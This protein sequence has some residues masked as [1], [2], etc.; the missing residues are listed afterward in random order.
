[1]TD[2][3][4]APQG[5]LPDAWTAYIGPFAEVLGK[6]V[7]DVTELLKSIVGEPNDQ[8][9]ILLKDVA[10]SPDADLKALLVGT[11]SAI[12]NQAISKLREMPVSHA[13]LAFSGAD[14]LPEVPSEES[15][16]S[17][18]RA[19][20]QL[21]VDQPSVISVVRASLAHRVGLFN[22]PSILADKMESFA[23]DNAQP[24][25]EEFYK[26]RKQVT[27]RNYGEIFAAIDGL[28]GSFISDKRRNELLSRVDTI[29]WPALFDF[30]SQLKAWV[31]AW[32][33]GAANPALMMNAIAA[34]AGGGSTMPPGMMAPPD[35]GTV[36]DQAESFNDSLNKVFAGTGI[37]VARALAFDAK[38]IKETLE[39]PSLP[40]MVGATNR[41]QMLRTL[42]VEVSAAYPRMEANLTKYVL[43]ILQVK[44]LAAGNEELQFFGS[45]AM[46]GSQ[47]PWD[48]LRDGHRRS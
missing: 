23:D 46:L 39:N 34:M 10:L 22:L 25:P 5:T 37:P 29:M 31:E 45:L 13:P 24:V 9:I 19:G 41:E 36:R 38:G 30:H 4:D 8:A 42:G 35:T 32:Q 40:A 1:M 47:I 33:Q 48:T 11:P 16:L 17:A 2:A 6:P 28:D 27:R 20:G 15:W 12:A 7:Q 26:L 21:K 18:L 3:H 14:I 43:A 44:D